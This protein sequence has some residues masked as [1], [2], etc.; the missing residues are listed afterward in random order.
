MTNY[1]KVGGL[2]YLFLT[3]LESRKSKIKVLTDFVTGE[4]P[5]TDLQMMEKQIISLISLLIKAPSS[6]RWL[7]SHN[8]RFHLITLSHWG[9]GFHHLDFERIHII[10]P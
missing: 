5:L 9:L 8:Q 6:S 1:Y 2:K 10:R 7:H 4:G 3:V